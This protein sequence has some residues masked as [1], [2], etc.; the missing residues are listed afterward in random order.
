MTKVWIQVALGVALAVYQCCQRPKFLPATPLA[1]ACWL[2]Y[3]LCGVSGLRGDCCSSA[4][5]SWHHGRRKGKG[6][7]SHVCLFHQEKTKAFP[8]YCQIPSLYFFSKTGNLGHP[9]PTRGGR[10]QV[11]NC[12][13]ISIVDTGKGGKKGKDRK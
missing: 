7:D 2:F 10:P 4:Y 8:E 5:H 12:F 13:S 9:L 11:S 6:Q 1:L 3:F